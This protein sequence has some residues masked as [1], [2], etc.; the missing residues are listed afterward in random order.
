[1]KILQNFG[2]FKKPYE[3]NDVKVKDHCH[4][5]GKYG[6]P[7]HEKC[8]INLNLNRKIAV[9]FHNLW[10]FYLHLIFK[11][12][13]TFDFNRSKINVIPKTL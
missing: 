6:G 8:N 10:I 9:V 5:T 4:I 12:L 1:M 3:N 2:F 7:A 13:E 11:E